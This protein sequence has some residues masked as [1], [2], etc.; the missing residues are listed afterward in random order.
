MYII[1]NIAKP[2]ITK[3]EINTVISVMQSG[4]IAFGSY[5]TEF[6]EAFSSYCN[7]KY[8]IATS[9]GTTAL[10]V[11]L[12]ACGITK[13]D[14]V[15]TTCF[16]FIASVNSI[17][18]TGA[19][20]VFADIDE[21]TFNISTKS[22]KKILEKEVGIKAIL[23]VH[24]FGQCC[25]MDEI[26]ELV[27]KYNLILIE[28]CCQ[29]H[30]AEWKGKK[31]GSFGEAGCFSF[32]PTKNMT[33]GEGGMIVTDKKHIYEN[34]KMLTNHGMKVR[35]YHDIIGYN[36]R[37]TNIAAA[38]GLRQL[39]KLDE[40]NKKRTENAFVLDENIN[41]ELL[42]KPFVDKNTK[43]T[44]NQ[45]TLKIR[46]AKRDQFVDYLKKNDIGTGVYYSLTIPEQKCYSEYSFQ[47]K[48]N[49]ADKVKKE[50]ASIPVHP[51]VTDDKL[52]LIVYTINK[53]KG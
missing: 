7:C 49:I 24:L 39:E 28:D 12:R 26:M 5:V 21:K 17:L 42:E 31:A 35:Y 14:R 47:R 11:A 43:H 19:L 33:T 16:S 18:N 41:N 48:F 23:I 51:L 13:N 30:G 46:Q 37:M 2:I 34:A 36:Y 15:I 1:I 44:Y 20:P 32:Y 27:R 45:Y 3:E 40:F 8:G 6:E 22:V 29:S 53:F 38:I 25:D 10:E 9:S 4:N 52:E 50:V